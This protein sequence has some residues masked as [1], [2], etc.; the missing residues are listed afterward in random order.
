MAVFSG[1]LSEVSGVLS[2]TSEVLSVLS[3]S[4]G[5]LS[6]SSAP[7]IVLTKPGEHAVKSMGEG[8]LATAAAADGPPSAAGAGVVHL[9]WVGTYPMSSIAGLSLP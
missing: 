3:V 4:W 8:A 9:G 6:V 7:A 5:L 2:V 1:V